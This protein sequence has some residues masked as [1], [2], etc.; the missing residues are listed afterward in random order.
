M[1][2]LS[3]CRRKDKFTLMRYSGYSI[4]IAP[5]LLSGKMR[6]KINFM[7]Y[8]YI[9]YS[10]WLKKGVSHAIA[11]I[12]KCSK[13][14]Q[15]LM[16]A[17]RSSTKPCRVF[18]DLT[19]RADSWKDQRSNERSWTEKEIKG[20]RSTCRYSASNIQEASSWQIVST[21]FTSWQIQYILF[22]IIH[23]SICIEKMPWTLG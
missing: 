15:C 4:F 16:I 18:I 19:P 10:V 9:S 20:Q 13:H 1:D 23:V 11:Q 21:C 8:F 6:S 7:K 22:I 12:I 17:Y 3:N 2:L 14:S 5:Q